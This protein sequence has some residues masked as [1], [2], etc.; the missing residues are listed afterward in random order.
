MKLYAGFDGGG[1]KTTCTDAA[2][3]RELDACIAVLE[4]SERELPN[5]RTVTVAACDLGSRLLLGLP[6]E[7]SHTDGDRLA[8]EAA[9]RCG[10]PAHVV[11]YCGGYDGYLP[12]ENRGI[13]Y[14]DIAT[15]YL[16]EA[17]ERIW[18][19]VLDCAAITVK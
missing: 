1:S 6:F 11:C 19:A 17:R 5:T 14:Q 13:N 18:Q 15:G 3:R 7:V 12:H 10:K 2:A 4:R 16:P 9:A 8:Q